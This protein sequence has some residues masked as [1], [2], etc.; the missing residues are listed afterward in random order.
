[1]CILLCYQIDRYIIIRANWVLI[2]I[3]KL[4]NTLRLKIIRLK[5]RLALLDN[6]LYVTDAR[7]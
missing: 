5:E 3:F 7:N 2:T 1:M 6:T 4:L